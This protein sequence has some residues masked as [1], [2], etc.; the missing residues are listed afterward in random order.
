MARLIYRGN[1]YETNPQEIDVIPT[2]VVGRYRGQF[3]RK[4]TVKTMPIDTRDIDLQYRGVKYHLGEAKES[5]KE[6][7]RQ[8]DVCAQ[9]AHSFDCTHLT[10]IRRNIEH[11]LQVAQAKGDE[12]L[13]RMLMDEARQLV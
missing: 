2:A 8:A 5:V 1:E 7:F 3:W 12:A 9:N 4:N 6:Y 13:V 10:N 11:R